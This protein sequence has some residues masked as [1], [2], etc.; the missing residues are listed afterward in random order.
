MDRNKVIQ[1]TDVG[2]SLVTLSMCMPPRLCLQTLKP[3]NLYSAE[4]T[5]D[6]D[7]N[8]TFTNDGT[9]NQPLMMQTITDS[10]GVDTIDLSNQ[11]KS[12]TLNMNGGTLSTIGYWSESR[13][14]GILGCTDR[15]NTT[16]SNRLQLFGIRKQLLIF[17][18]KQHHTFIPVKTILVLP[19]M[20]QIENAIGGLSGDDHY[21]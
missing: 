11:T 21:R 6:G 8:Y 1:Y 15:I 12:N 7:T 3:W 10:G 2:S 14:N 9:R 5:S 17:Q 18:I 13:P 20:R 4:T 19:M 16:N